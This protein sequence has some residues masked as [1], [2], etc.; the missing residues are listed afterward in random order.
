MHCEIEILLYF[1]TRV[2]GNV[3][4][5]KQAAKKVYKYYKF[6]LQV[7]KKLLPLHSLI[8]TEFYSIANKL[9]SLK[10]CRNSECPSSK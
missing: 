10:Y 8:K 9:S 3:V 7:L 5:S 1:C 2:Q 6:Y 4:K